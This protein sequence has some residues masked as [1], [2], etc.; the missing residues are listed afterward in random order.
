MAKE[1]HLEKAL[2]EAR[3][4]IAE[5][6]NELDNLRRSHGVA[7]VGDSPKCRN[8]EDSYVKR[9]A[10]PGLPIKIRRLRI[11]LVEDSHDNVRVIRAFLDRMGQNLTVAGN[12]HEAMELLS[13]EPFDL[14]LMDVELPIMNG[15]DATRH[16]R[17]GAAGEAARDL[18]IIAL[19]AHAE[20]GFRE[21]CREAGMNESLAKPVSMAQIAQAIAHVQDGMPGSMTSHDAFD[22]ETVLEALDGDVALLM[23]LYRIFIRTAPQRLEEIETAV[24]E[25]NFA[26][27]THVAHAFKGNTATIGATRLHATIVELHEALMTEKIETA[28]S[29]LTTVRNETAIVLDMLLEKLG[30]TPPCNE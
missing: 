7:F 30:D 2:L 28:A 10:V 22:T 25:G 14:V 18:P 27:A 21:L 17:S 13:S 20:P 15:L 23:E 19:T 4:R 11:L 29:M 24:A 5:L 1:R 9:D 12:G 16:I 6:E 26:L 3:R 8:A